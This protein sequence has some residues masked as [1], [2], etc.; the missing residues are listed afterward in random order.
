[1]NEFSHKMEAKKMLKMLE[2]ELKDL[3]TAK[4]NEEMKIKQKI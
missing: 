2:K 3:I 1:M 4:M